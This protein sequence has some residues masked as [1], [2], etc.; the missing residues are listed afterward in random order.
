[1]GLL[2]M[3]VVSVCMCVCVYAIGTEYMYVHYCRYTSLS[4]TS[5]DINFKKKIFLPHRGTIVKSTGEKRSPLSFPEPQVTPSFL[6]T[7][8]LGQVS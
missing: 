6:S 8:H 5:F 1:M 7:N 2:C 4:I 3:G